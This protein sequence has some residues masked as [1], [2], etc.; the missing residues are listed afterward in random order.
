MK[1]QKYWILIPSI[2]ALIF[3]STGAA[4][5]GSVIALNPG[6]KEDPMTFSGK[7]GGTKQTPDC[8]KVAATPNHQIK[9]TQDFQYLRFSLQ[10]SG[11]PTLLIQEPGGKRT[12][13]SADSFSEGNIESPGYWKQGLYSIYVGDR[14]GKANQYTLSLT[15][16][17][18]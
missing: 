11:N 15:Q 3:S 7:S 18:N 8:G 4:L 14:A 16:K 10:S 1:G 5:S 6:F 17:N 2:I 13:L 12:C 9:M